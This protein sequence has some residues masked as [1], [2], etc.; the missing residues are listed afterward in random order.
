MQESGSATGPEVQ[1]LIEA[2][3]DPK[4]ADELMRR[5]GWTRDD[6]LKRADMVS[7]KIAASISN[8]AVV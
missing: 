3:N 4:K 2:M 6:L 7:K 1:E 8:V 5:N